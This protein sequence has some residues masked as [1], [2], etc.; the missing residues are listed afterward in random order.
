MR[1]VSYSGGPVGRNASILWES[2]SVGL[3]LWKPLLFLPLCRYNWGKSERGDSSGFFS[4]RRALRNNAAVSGAR[5]GKRHPC[6]PSPA[7][8]TSCF[9]SADMFVKYCLAEAV[10]FS[11]CP[12]SAALDFLSGL[13]DGVRRWHLQR[14]FSYK[15]T[16]VTFKLLPAASWN[17]E[18]KAVFSRTRGPF[19]TIFG[20]NFPTPRQNQWVSLSAKKKTEASCGHHVVFIQTIHETTRKM[21][22]VKKKLLPKIQQTTSHHTFQSILQTVKLA[23]LRAYKPEEGDKTQIYMKRLHNLRK[24]CRLVQ[25]YL[26]G[27]L[28]KPKQVVVAWLIVTY[29][30]FGRLKISLWLESCP[31]VGSLNVS[32]P[33][34]KDRR[35]T[36]WYQKV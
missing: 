6:L 8:P 14:L 19:I 24:K 3:A 11:L 18:N 30:F 23:R 1:C 9:Y 10:A 15:Q 5:R 29:F 17:Q 31:H 27:T 34:W 33:V 21:Y 20:R 16:S 22:Q 13:S 28:R 35:G 36:R 7:S 2:R 32:A 26:D 25:I 4:E 12:Q